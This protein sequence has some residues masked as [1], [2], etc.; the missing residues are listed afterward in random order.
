MTFV[1]PSIVELL[2]NRIALWISIHAND[3]TAERAIIASNERDQSITIT[4]SQ[5]TQTSS[6]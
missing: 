4:F 6:I 1:V 2:M 3:W 5:L